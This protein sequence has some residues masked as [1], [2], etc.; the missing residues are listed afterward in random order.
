MGTLC[1][2]PFPSFLFTGMAFNDSEEWEVSVE[3]IERCSFASWYPVFKDVTFKSK[4]FTLD[5]EHPFVK[6]LHSDGVFVHHDRS[7]P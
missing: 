3:D 1:S 2:W 6:Y 4:V 5:H 7:T